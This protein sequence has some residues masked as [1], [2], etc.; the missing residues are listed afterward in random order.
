VVYLGPVGGS[1]P[2]PLPGGLISFPQNIS[3]ADFDEFVAR[4]Q[5]ATSRPLALHV[6][7]ISVQQAGENL[8]AN[9]TAAGLGPTP[10]VRA[11]VQPW[12]DCPRCGVTRHHL[13]VGWEEPDGARL[14][15]RECVAAA[16]AATWR[17]EAPEDGD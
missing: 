11:E 13:F 12:T 17:E 10:V 3:Q 16:C 14:A 9:L 6:E 7:G 15:L 5:T 8:R 1:E 4:W 2:G